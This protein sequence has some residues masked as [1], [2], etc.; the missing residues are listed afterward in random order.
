[1]YVTSREACKQLGLHPN[2]LRK[3]ADNA[4]IKYYK[5]ESGQRRYDIEAYLG[6]VRKRTVVCY[7]RVSSYKQK[8]DLQR[9][10]AYMADK[11]PEA[12]IVKDIGSGL[13]YKRKGLKSL[14]DRAIKG[15]VIELMVAHKDRLARFG[16]ELITQVIE[17]S[18]GKVVVLKQNNLSP[19]QEL[20]ADLLHILPVF[21]CRMHG[22]RNYK[23]QVREA[24]S[25]PKPKDNMA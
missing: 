16:I 21:S 23:N 13:N 17:S 2:T 18:G 15:E 24:V 25:Q 14:L 3:L 19:E 1:M 20:T 6:I 10:I 11:Y 9:Q 5:T 7:C 8:D 12:E 22:L 4:K